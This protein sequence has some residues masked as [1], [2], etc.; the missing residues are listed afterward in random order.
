MQGREGG[1]KVMYIRIYI[2]HLYRGMDGGARGG[3]DGG[4]VAGWLMGHI[5][6]YIIKGRDYARIYFIL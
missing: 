6:M 4:E 2:H 1:K 3:G 5:H